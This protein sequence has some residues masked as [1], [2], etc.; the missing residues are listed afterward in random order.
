MRETS[1][2]KNI[3]KKII[4]LDPAN[5]EVFRNVSGDQVFLDHNKYAVEFGYKGIALV[6][7]YFKIYR[8]Y[9]KAYWK[10]FLSML[11]RRCYFGTFN[12]EFGNF[13]SYVLPFLTYLHSKKVKI[14]YCGLDLYEPFMVAENGKS[15]IHEFTRLPDFYNEVVPDANNSDRLPEIHK[16]IIKNFA[17]RAQKSF[18][19]FWNMNDSFF[20]WF[21]FREWIVKAGP[22]M[23]ASRLE[24]V[25]KTAEENSVVI[26]PR[27][28]KDVKGRAINYG[29]VWDFEEIINTAKIY[30]DKVYVMGHP[31]MSSMPIVSYD[32]VEVLITANNKIL[33]EKCSNSRLIITQHSG[34]K[35]L[36]EYTNSQVLVIH[37]GSLPIEGI[38][39]NIVYNY[40]LGKRHSL[41]YA[42]SINEI[43]S[44]CQ[45]FK[46]KI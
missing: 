4:A 2:H 1:F 39:F 40:F 28:K 16:G 8:G 41:H 23:K 14:Y 11:F 10:L 33:L 32:N 9:A 30:F 35:Y 45:K 22:F 12:G 19:P 25:Y 17:E 21:I 24:K 46:N 18:F 31:A 37:K 5:E 34:T 20:Y 42:F 36:G 44:Y 7:Y 29:E 3:V 26:F 6:R 27:F 38:L 15:I 13:L 43:K